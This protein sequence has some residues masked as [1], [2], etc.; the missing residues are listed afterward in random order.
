[1]FKSTSSA[2][3]SMLISTFILFPVAAVAPCLHSLPFSSS[4]FKYGSFDIKP[5]ANIMQP[6]FDD[7]VK[8]PR[9]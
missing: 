3:V 8:I 2:S 9:R 1:L 6:F 7:L 5:S 4:L